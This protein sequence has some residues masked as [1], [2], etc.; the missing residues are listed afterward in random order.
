MKAILILILLFSFSAKA[1]GPWI[2]GP[3]QSTI[4][5]PFDNKVGIGTSSPSSSLHIASNLTGA[6]SSYSVRNST[7]IQSDV[8]TAAGVYRSMPSTQATAFTLTDLYG[9]LASNVTIGAGSAVTNQY[10]FFASAQSSA[11]NNYAFYANSSANTGRWN[12]YANGTAQNYFAGNTMIG[13]TNGSAKLTVAGQSG[14]ASAVTGSVAHISGVDSTASIVQNDAYNGQPT[15]VLRRSNGTASVPTALANGDL[16]GV[17]SMRGYGA[18][19]Y[20][21]GSRIL[22]A[23]E[24]AEAWTD[25]AQGASIRFAT[26]PIGSTTNTIVAR[27]YENGAMAIGADSKAAKLTVAGQSG[28]ATPISNSNLHISGAD[29][30]QNN[31]S[32]D[33]YGESSNIAFRRAQG[34]QASPTAITSGVSLGSVG[35]RGYGSTAYASGSRVLIQA[36]AS[37]T[38][39]DTAQGT[40]LGFST[41][42]NGST[43]IAERMRIQNSGNVSIG[44]TTD[45]AKLLVAG[46]S[47]VATPVSNTTMHISG[48]DSSSHFLSMDAYGGV[49][50]LVFR[51]SNGTQ[52]S[53]TA[54]S[55]AGSMGGV[56]W[57]GYGSTAYSSS[58]RASVTAQASEAWTDSAQGSRVT[59]GA[60]PKSSTTQRNVM[61]AHG[62]GVVSQ[63]QGDV[64]SKAAAA[65]LTAD[66]LITKIIQYTGTGDNL[67]LPTASDIQTGIFY[68]SDNLSFDFSVINTGSGSATLTTNTGLT[69]VGSMV[70][71]AGASGMFRVRRVTSSAY[72]IYRLN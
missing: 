48:A 24:A 7:S 19:A 9:F 69:L 38:W 49:N 57:F 41:T 39:T 17:I 4:Q 30:T 35:W 68:P 61:I 23:G 53:P 12:F 51:N 43:S 31:L 55:A 71:T 8:T 36:V 13:S 54:L 70:V 34:T 66:E 44:S 5:V 14:V 52:A 15:L 62:N 63:Y 20:S 56:Y 67:Q 33:S 50:G 46:Q 26:T 21:S 25:S 65:T 59:I 40:Y 45:S 32:M 72:T 60:T 37:Q 64:T 42:P 1:Y 47:G 16:F 2:Y 27:M 18:S 11:T 22:I 3:N 29:S 58:S 28:V 10:G 6:A